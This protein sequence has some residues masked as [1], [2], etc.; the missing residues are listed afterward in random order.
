MSHPANPVTPSGGP[1]S[2]S[3]T[4]TA[5]NRDSLVPIPAR[6]PGPDCIHRNVKGAAEGGQRFSAERGHPVFPV[7]LP[8]SSVS[9]SI[10]E[11]APGA[12]TSNHRHGYES[13][14]YIICGHGYTIMEGLFYNFKACY[15]FYTPPWCW[16]Q[17]VAEKDSAVQYITATNMPLL[18][19]MGQ[20]VLREE[21][22]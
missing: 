21:A 17:H 7:K 10:G 14:V 6:P 5:K 15:E 12:A 2:E 19:R 18:Q 4:D 8:S 11:L 1:G 13:L 16:H 9:Y 3:F 20:T 22:R